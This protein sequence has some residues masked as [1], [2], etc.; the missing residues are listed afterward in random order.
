MDGEL[1]VAVEEMPAELPLVEVGPSWVA[2]DLLVCG[3]KWACDDSE[4]G[5]RLCGPR[6]AGVRLGQNRSAPALSC[7]SGTDTVYSPRPADQRPSPTLMTP[8]KRSI[9]IAPTRLCLCA[10]SKTKTLPRTA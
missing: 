1:A 8:A 10:S 5:V 4:V 9:S 3:R 6:T 7:Q 2:L